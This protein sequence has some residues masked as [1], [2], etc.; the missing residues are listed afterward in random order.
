[1]Q[2]GEIALSPDGL[3][4]AFVRSRRSVEQNCVIDEL[5]LTA[6]AGGSTICI[7][8]GT[9]PVWHPNGLSLFFEQEENGV[10]F[11]WQ[12][13]LA[14]KEKKR[15]APV[16]H[17][18]YFLGHL[19]DKKFT[20]SPDGRFL[21]YISTPPPP[22]VTGHPAIVVVERLLYK[23]RG[24]RTR[25]LFADGG[26]SQIWLLPLEGGVPLM[27]TTGNYHHY[28]PCWSADGRH[29]AFICNR[30]DNPDY[31]HRSTLWTV[32]ADTGVIQEVAA[33]PGTRF[34]PAWSP[35][36]LHIATL[37]TASELSSKDSPADDTQVYITNVETGKDQCIS[38][39]LDRRADNLC[40]H[41]GAQA[42][43]FTAGDK[44]ATNIYMAGLN[45]EVKP[46]VTGNGLIKE[47][48]M[49]GSGTR[50]YF[51]RNA[52]TL[53]DEIYV[54]DANTGRERPLTDLHAGLLARCGFSPAETF[55]FASH[56]ETAVQGWLMKPGGWREN[57]RY[58][59][60][61]VVHGGPHNMFGFEFEERMQLLAANG[62]GVLFI[63]PRGSHGYGQAF[64][65]GT[66]LNWG[67]HDFKDLMAGL[68]HVIQ[69][70]SWIDENRLGITGQSYGG[71]MANW[72][73][74]QTSRFRAAVV[75]GGI[76]NLVSFA[77]TS[78]YHLLT[79]AEFGKPWDNYSLLWQWSPLCHVKHV[80]TPA[81]FLHGERDYEVPVQQA[82]EMYTALKKLGVPSVMVRYME[83][84]HGW[85]PD[86]RP[87][88]RLDVYSRMVQWFDKYL[89]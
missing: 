42:V 22:A 7:G 1:M 9:S 29:I 10:P 47:Y 33:H 52:V 34:K 60:L 78:L 53:P 61:L 26:Y 67:G 12:Y 83:E 32:A 18:D 56:D 3:T 8:K 27:L 62:Y 76:S 45:G 63:N 54:Y 70:H 59:L 87:L 16:Y 35:D 81:L 23:T 88:N 64:S 85:R 31:N 11:I 69:R 73:I 43:Y 65:M 48:C 80:R 72:A 55:W 41:P 71:F 74:T 2:L 50:L 77:G 75:D 49:D 24:G 57:V 17:S 37:V 28:S 66:L 46:V 15:L 13:H 51:I 4:L 79:E 5:L 6:T 89:L 25:P 39:Q 40:W 84:G 36:N 19:A 20:I 30:T 21:A 86:L 38:A 58:P 68:D 14:S 82:E 44:G